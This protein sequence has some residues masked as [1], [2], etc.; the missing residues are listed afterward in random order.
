MVRLASRYLKQ[1]AQFVN[2]LNVF[3]VPDGDTGTNMNLTFQSGYKAVNEAESEN[4]GELAQYLAKGLLMGARGNSGVITSQIFRGFAKSVQGKATLNSLDL[5]QALADGVKTVY[6]AV[7][8][9]VEGTILTVAKQASVQAQAVGNQAS[10]ATTVMVSALEGAQTALAQTP[11]LLPVLKE[12]GVVDSGGQG[13]VFIYEGFVE[14]LGGEVVSKDHYQPDED[15]MDEMLN[16]A[17][18]QSVQQNQITTADITTADIKNGFCTEMM[19]Q[20]GQD[21]TSKELFD[22]QG[23]REHLSELGDSLLV[24]AD[25]EVVKVHVHTQHPQKIFTYGRCYGALSK[26]KIDNMRIQH[27]SIVE[28]EKPQASQPQKDYGIIVVASGAGLQK[29]FKSLGVTNIISGGQTMNPST[30]DIVAAIKETNAQRVLIL[31]NNG[32]IVMAA[33]QASQVVE[34][35]TAIVPSKSIAQGMTALLSFDTTADLASN[36]EDMT[37][38]LT[39]VKSGQITTA[40]RDSKL[41][42]LEIKENDYIGLVDGKIV[43]NGT[44]I[45][46]LGT[47]LIA[48]MV[49]EESEIVT[50]LVGSQGKSKEAQALESAIADQF[51]ELECEI[52]QG[53][54]PVYHYLIAVE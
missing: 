25:E 46:E 27:E 32:N 26:I 42:N 48:Q 29:L 40:V 52:H 24:V 22:Y 12:V 18:R 41:D 21:P 14:A 50:I 23:F 19:V 33:Q 38:A 35:P 43:A 51:P 1:N 34:I 11:E 9:P 39:T 17:H 28:T 8:K 30:Q 36:Q 7:M 45:L 44:D 10:D 5:A 31:P 54:Q 47:E 4:V 6:Q 37:A 49:D 53:D 13:L 20:L 3:P 16:A 2:S 15:E